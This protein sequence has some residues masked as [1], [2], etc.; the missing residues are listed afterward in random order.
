[1]LLDVF[2]VRRLRA[3]SRRRSASISSTRPRV[4]DLD[5]AYLPPRPFVAL[6]AKLALGGAVSYASLPGTKQLMMIA[7]RWR[8]IPHHGVAHRIAGGRGSRRAPAPA[9]HSPFDRQPNRRRRAWSYSVR[10]PSLTVA[11]RHAVRRDHALEPGADLGRDVFRTVRG[12]R[13]R[14]G[15][16][17]KHPI[18]AT[19]SAIPSQS[20]V[21][22]GH[23][24]RI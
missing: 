15:L 5:A 2:G 22:D 16:A 12:R 9:S 20:P 19:T 24:L 23:S 1:M 3:C 6:G 4:A 11:A 13:P 10:W 18:E 17:V 7:P 8:N 14:A 21:H